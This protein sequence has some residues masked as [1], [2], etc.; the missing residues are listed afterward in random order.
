MTL[1]F[2]QFHNPKRPPPIR[3]H[4]EDLALCW[5]IN[6][7]VALRP[8][9]DSFIAICSPPASVLNSYYPRGPIRQQSDIFHFAPTSPTN[10]AHLAFWTTKVRR[11]SATKAW[12]ASAWGMTASKP[13]PPRSPSPSCH[14]R[15]GTPVEAVLQ[16]HDIKG[17]QDYSSKIA[18]IGLYF[19]RIFRKQIISRDFIGPR[20]PE[21][22]PKIAMSDV[23]C[24]LS[25]SR[26]GGAGD[27]RSNSGRYGT[28]SAIISA[29]PQIGSSTCQNFGATLPVQSRHGETSRG[30]RDTAE[31][32]I[33][34]PGIHRRST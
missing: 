15:C 30:P 32:W 33:F 17:A 24:R 3:A 29:T 14:R 19:T 25:G 1:Q 7:K 13:H 34:A 23:G 28:S 26:E 4:I 18:L 11:R 21:Y 2:L 12:H 20:A 5:V 27:Q 22:S 31:I 10:R 9:P 6:L 16:P 8:L